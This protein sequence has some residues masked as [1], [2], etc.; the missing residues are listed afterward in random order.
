M[1]NQLPIVFNCQDFIQTHEPF[2]LWL[3]SYANKINEKRFFYKKYLQECIKISK[4]NK[5][6][7]WLQGK[8]YGLWLPDQRQFVKLNSDYKIIKKAL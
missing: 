6:S 2:S 1:I 4:G 8:S 7:Y 3:I 5:L